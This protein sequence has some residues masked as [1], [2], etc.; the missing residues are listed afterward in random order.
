MGGASG[1]GAF[2]AAEQA[3]LPG[4]IGDRLAGENGDVWLLPRG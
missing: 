4:K 2:A 3:E 1:G